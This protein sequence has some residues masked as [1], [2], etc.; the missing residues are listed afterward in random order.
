MN[1]G[2]NRF[3]CFSLFVS[4]WD[5]DTFSFHYFPILP[6]IGP[7]IRVYRSHSTWVCDGNS[8]PKFHVLCAYQ[9][10]K[11]IKSSTPVEFSCRGCAYGPPSNDFVLIR[12][13]RVG[14]IAFPT[15]E[16]VWPVWIFSLV[17]IFSSFFFTLRSLSL[18]QGWLLVA[19]DMLL[20]FWLNG[21]IL[22]DPYRSS[23]HSVR[24]LE[25][26]HS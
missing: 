14:P 26:L 8:F 3:Q 20:S 17:F 25:Q 15:W 5:Q 22:S 7:W 16:L 18:Q 13:R 9:K 24:L 2:D 12:I 10:Y 21:C 23:S 1:P 6:T 19:H 11:D 4:W